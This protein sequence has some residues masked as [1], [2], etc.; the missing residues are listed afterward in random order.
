[1]KSW[2]WLGNDDDDG[3]VDIKGRKITRQKIYDIHV[4]IKA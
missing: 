3:I 4:F 2:E 1:M